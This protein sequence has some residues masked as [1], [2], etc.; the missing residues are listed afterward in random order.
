MEHRAVR[1]LSVAYA[2]GGGRGHVTR[3]LAY[4]AR[5]GDPNVVVLHSG[6]PMAAPRPGMRLITVHSPEEV[7]ATIE[8]LGAAEHLIVDTFPG[9]L[10][11][12]LS[13]ELLGA[14]AK[15]TLIKRFVRSGSYDDYESLAARFGEQLLPYPATGCEWDGEVAGRYVGYVTRPLRRRGEGEAPLCVIGP[16][17]ELPSG[18]QHHLPPETEWVFGPLHSLPKARRYLALGAGYN[19]TYELKQLRV[20]ARTVPRERRWDDQ[21]ARAERLGMG[22]H[23]TDA[24][25]RW[26][27]A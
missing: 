7:C 10:F 27:A 22:L 11:H 25:R 24:L 9:G 12:E 16:P 20:D 2:L 6:A 21:Y 26:L 1:Q 17:D 13:E 15:T 4:L 18:W 3:V 8:T 19:L 14:F 5:L 23:N